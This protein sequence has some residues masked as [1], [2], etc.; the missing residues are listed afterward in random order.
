MTLFEGFSSRTEEFFMAIAF[1]NN[2][3]FFHENHAWYEEAVRRP[4]KELAAALAPVIEEIDSNLEHRPERVVSRI[5]RDVRFSKDKSPYRDYMWLSFRPP[6]EAQSLS[7]C[8]YFE[9]SA[10]GAS[11]G[12]GLYD[13]NR[14]LLNGLRRC[15]LADSPSFL[16]IVQPLDKDFNRHANLFRRR[17]VPEDLT[18]DAKSW[19]LTRSFFYEKPLDDEIT[20]SPRLTDE[21]STG[22]KKLTPLYRY[23]SA[24][25]PVE[26][27]VL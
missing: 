23:L 14:P 18:D 21:I 5:N 26:A 2:T 8:F 3:A 11:Y 19:F 4:M 10:S 12:M 24:I 16:E 9:I 25:E 27:D 1:N 7:L 15:L 6:H 22:F 20:H 17:K 13:E